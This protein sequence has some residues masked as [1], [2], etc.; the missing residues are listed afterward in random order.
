V[1]SD[2]DISIAAGFHFAARAGAVGQAISLSMR[3]LRT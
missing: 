2:M 3:T 1:V